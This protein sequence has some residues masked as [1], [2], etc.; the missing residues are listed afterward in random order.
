MH[1][2][3]AAVEDDPLDSGGRIIEGGNLGTVK[4]D[5]GKS[6]RLAFLGQKAWCNACNSAG[7]I[8]AAPGS[9][10]KKRL[11]DQQRGRQ[12]ALAGDLVICKCERRPRILSVYGRKWQIVADNESADSTASVASAMRSVIAYDDRFVLCDA[13]GTPL[14]H[15][16][17]A[18][19]RE[20]GVFEYGETDGNGRTH[21]LSS[22][23]AAEPINIYLAG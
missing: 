19:R 5:D 22:T 9:P 10:S 4:G 1:I 3:Y 23:V 15:E 17:Y 21:L 20:T 2:F 13:D 7:I 16:A 12:Q 14:A 11:Y 8:V 6:R 18:L